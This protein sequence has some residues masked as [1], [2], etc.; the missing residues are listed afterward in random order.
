MSIISLTIAPLLK[1]N[2]DDWETWYY[3]LIPLALMFLG[4]VMVY[5]FFWRDMHDITADIGI[6]AE[7]AKGDD[8]KKEEADAGEGKA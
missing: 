4:T 7:A 2:P 3:G 8:A 1:S 5:W 6:A